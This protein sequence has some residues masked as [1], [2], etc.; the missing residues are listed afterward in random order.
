M[1]T[2]QSPVIV[3]RKLRKW[4]SI[5][6]HVFHV[7]PFICTVQV[8]TATLHTLELISSSLR[9]A[10]GVLA[11]L[12]PAKWPLEDS[13]VWPAMLQLHRPETKS[14]FS[15]IYFLLTIVRFC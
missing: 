14:L 1:F 11:Q 12:G 9:L 7:Q 8:K 2:K 13:R 15:K 10:L 6:D 5:L 4:N 3:I